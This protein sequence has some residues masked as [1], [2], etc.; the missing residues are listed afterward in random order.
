M[1]L[2]TVSG[3]VYNSFGVAVPNAAINFRLTNLNGQIPVITSTAIIVPTTVTLTTNSSGV[4]TGSIQGNDTITPSG[5]LY[6][7]SF[8]GSDFATY[9][10]VGAGPINLNSYSPITM[11]PPPNGTVPTNILTGNNIFSGNNSFTGTVTLGPLIFSGLLTSYNGI[12]TVAN[13]IPSIYAQA[14]TTGLTA[15]VSTTTL[16]AVPST[17]AGIYRL[18]ASLITTATGTGNVNATITYNNGTATNTLTGSTVS[19]AVSGAEATNEFRFY[20][21]A[22]QNIS[23]A[24]TYTTTG[25][26]AIRLRLEY[27]G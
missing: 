20:A 11:Q 10:F 17:G 8:A 13:G 18:S 21:A 6:E 12:S 15:A 9:S 23:Y 24:T 2:I 22:S 16:Y 4:F 19:L 3:T 26:Y 5:T 27:L 7:V 1:A 25:T 14:N